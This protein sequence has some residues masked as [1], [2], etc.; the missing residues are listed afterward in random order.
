MMR[1]RLAR[2]KNRII[3]RIPAGGPEQAAVP[4]PPV[5]TP[6]AP[7]DASVT[8][9]AWYRADLGI[10]GAAP[11]TALADQSGAGDANRNQAAINGTLNAGDIAY[12]G[13]D[14]ISDLRANRGGAWSVAPATPITIV[15]IG[16]AGAV[17]SLISD[18]ASENMLWNNA[19]PVARLYSTT[20]ALA[21]LVDISAPSAV[22]ATDDGATANLYVNDFTAPSV[23]GATW[24]TGGTTG[25]DLGIGV[26]GV[27]NLVGKIAEIMVFGGLL[28][29]TDLTNLRTYLNTTRAYGLGIV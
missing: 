20:G 25:F 11:V 21:S 7:T 17:K 1:S 24:L 14:T 4:T 12:G 29:P 22:M 26:A 15:V 18:G 3:E 10:T 5:V 16:E 8:L 27:G 28:T 13:N 23:S 2:W 6:W 9:R 19:D